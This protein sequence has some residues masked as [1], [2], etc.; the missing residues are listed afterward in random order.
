MAY[1]KTILCLANS[2][3]KAGS[4]IAGKE[5]LEE[6]FGEWIRPV[7]DRQFEEIPR[8]DLRYKDGS[9]AALL[10]IINI[11]MIEPRPKS[12]QSENHLYRSG[13]YW[14]RIG[15]ATWDEIVA[16]TD[17]LSGPLWVNGYSSYNGLNDRIPEA[18]ASTLKNSLL[19]INPSQLRVI[20][21]EEDGTY[22]PE[23]RVRADFRFS[24]HQYKLAVTDPWMEQHYLAG[25]DGSFAIKIARLCVSLGEIFQGFT[26]KLVAAVITPERAK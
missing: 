7:S 15:R 6:N 19:L 18:I 10:D 26:Y 14:A 4:C 9:S 25:S 21:A 5:V 22:G 12:Y 8:R 3:K 20:V 2:R 1:D 23:R 13:Y 24:G 11:S 16:A 17:K